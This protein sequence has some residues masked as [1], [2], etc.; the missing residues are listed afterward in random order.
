MKRYI[1]ILILL[2]VVLVTGTVSHTATA[3][4]GRSVKYD[5]V[6]S[7]TSSNYKKLSSVVPDFHQYSIT[8]QNQ[9]TDD[10]VWIDDDDFSLEKKEHSLF[11]L[12]FGNYRVLSKLPLRICVGL[13]NK[14]LFVSHTHKV[15]IYI[16]YSCLLIP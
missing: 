6:N 10:D 14:K 11:C 2:L 13:D 8:G 1:N 3:M 16:Q 4:Y 5:H 9:Y 7:Y 12:V 15:P